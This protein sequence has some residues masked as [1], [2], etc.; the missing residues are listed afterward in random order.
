VYY[1]SIVSSKK[2]AGGRPRNR[3]A[4]PERGER[5]DPFVRE[6]W[7]R[8][9]TVVLENTGISRDDLARALATNPD[10][11]QTWPRALVRRW[12]N[13]EVTVSSANAYEVGEALFKLGVGT[14]GHEAVF[15]SGHLPAY[16]GSLEYV[17][18]IDAL[19]ATKLAV[20]PRVR[21]AQ[22]S[23]LTHP[24]ADLENVVAQACDQMDEALKARHPRELRAAWDR[25]Q[26]RRPILGRK[27]GI[28]GA[29]DALLK[30]RL[31]EAWSIAAAPSVP[32]GMAARLA[33]E[34]LTSWALALRLPA[35]ERER[36]QGIA[37]AY[38][39]HDYVVRRELRSYR[40][41]PALEAMKKRGKKK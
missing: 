36:L 38:E 26:Q 8:W 32:P 4:V 5:I 30:S 14:C 10:D 15:M 7:A 41:L 40:I 1:V 35:G 11:K 17:A 27:A 9:L 6:R 12:L 2:D 23:G 34:V 20:L 19:T 3:I 39:D 16:I 31:E 33:L 21:W 24:D 29:L 22:T 37:D 25:Y 13:Q 28:P 18:E